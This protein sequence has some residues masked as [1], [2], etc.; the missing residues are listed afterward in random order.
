MIISFWP[1]RTHFDRVLVI[2][3]VTISFIGLSHKGIADGRSDPPNVVFILV[4][5]LGWDDVGYLG[6]EIKTPNIDSLAR[7][8][9]VLDH[10]YAFPICSPTRAALMTGHNPLRYGIDGAMENDAMLPEHLDLLPEYLRRSGYRTWMVGKWHLGMGVPEAMPHAR[11]FDYYYGHL[12]GFI[13]FYTHVYFGGLDWQRNGKSVREKGYATDLITREA[14]QLLSG[15]DGESPFF[16]FLSYNAPHTPLQYP[17]EAKYS[18]EEI[19]SK[20][21]RVFAQMTTYLDSAIGEV[22]SALEERDFLEN[23]LIVFMSD[24]GGNL[25]AGAHNGPLR[26]G[27]GSALE[28]G[29]RVPTFLAWK[30]GLVGNRTFDDP[31]FVQDWLPTLLAVAGVNYNVEDFDGRSA[32]VALESGQSIVRSGPVMIGAEHSKAVFDWPWKLLRD[33]TPGRGDQLYNVKVDPTEQID[34]ANKHPEL[35]QKLGAELDALP[36]RESRAA[37]GPKPESLF[38]DSSGDFDYDIRMPETRLPW[39]EA[40][41]AE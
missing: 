2:L 20:D 11:G 13:D 10:G 31:V 25:K 3:L 12:G 28:G 6:S 9:I 38:R 37:K 32:W 15:H 7:S 4:D 36:I 14:I 19:E 8:G 27:K 1:L 33:E 30:R 22:V 17:P 29:I 35:V 24:N 41:L 26:D 16:L 5:D 21:R 23:T 39:A 18:Y 34:L 40:A